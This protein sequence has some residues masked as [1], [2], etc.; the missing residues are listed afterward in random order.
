MKKLFA[1]LMAVCMMASLLC[2][3][4]FAADASTEDIVLRVSALKRD[5]T[6]VVIQDYTVFEDGWNAAMELASNPSRIR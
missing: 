1:I 6:T 3:T 2:V 5:D 4:A